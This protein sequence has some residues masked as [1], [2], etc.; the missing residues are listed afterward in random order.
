MAAKVT[1][2][3]PLREI[4][5]KYD[6]NTIT[7]YQAY[8]R[9]IAV[10]AVQGQRLDASPLF[11][12]GRMTWIKPSWCW[13]MYRSG[14][15]QKDKGQTNILAIKLTRGGLGELLSTACLSHG[16]D[17][18]AERHGQARV[19]WD[20]ERGPGLERL[21]HR[22]IQIGIPASMNEKFLGEWIVAIEDVTESALALKTAVEENP[23][24]GA[25]ELVEKGLIPSEN[26]YTVSE[27]IRRRLKMDGE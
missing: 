21:E 24:V 22:S 20:P 8:N 2:K 5:A 15:A 11:K 19:Q 6:E 4:R 25:A 23:S 14:Y 17:V 13:M 10:A 7:V 9:D 16:D 12:Y 1:T 26:T 18:K 27:G 3:T